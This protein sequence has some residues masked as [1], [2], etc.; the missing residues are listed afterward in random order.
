MA[1]DTKSGI[2]AM[3]T[4]HNNV[5]TINYYF[6]LNHL[7]LTQF[8][9]RIFLL[10]VL[11]IVLGDRLGRFQGER[12]LFQLSRRCECTQ[13]EIISDTTGVHGQLFAAEVGD[14]EDGEVGAHRYTLGEM[15]DRF[16]LAGQHFEAL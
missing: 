8:R 6:H 5:V 7:K 11:D 14:N 3:S 4:T 15:D 12:N 16:V 10:E 1:P 2:A 13:R 9:Q